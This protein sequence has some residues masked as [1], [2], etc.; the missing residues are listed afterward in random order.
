MAVCGAKN[1]CNLNIKIFAGYFSNLYDYY[2]LFREDV[3]EKKS[4]II[5]QKLDALLKYENESLSVQLFKKYMKEYTDDNIILKEIT[6]AYNDI[7]SNDERSEKMNEKHREI[8]EIQAKMEKLL[9][10]YKKTENRDF[11][12]EAIRTHIDELLPTVNS[13]GYLMFELCEMEVLEEGKEK[14][15][16]LVQKPNRIQKMDYTFNEPAKVVKFV[17]K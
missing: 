3:E 8:D 12:N 5:K 17:A 15:N 2:K 6:H 11:L 7:Y 1:K 4:K 14:T 9:M 13:L 16:I 10:E